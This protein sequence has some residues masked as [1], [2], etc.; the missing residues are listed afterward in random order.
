MLEIMYSNNVGLMIAKVNKWP[1][2]PKSIII[3]CFLESVLKT[4]EERHATDEVSFVSYFIYRDEIV[5]IC[6]FRFQSQGLSL[7]PWGT[8]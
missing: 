4:C 2:E 5:P 3:T 1:T 6:N 7:L 8:P